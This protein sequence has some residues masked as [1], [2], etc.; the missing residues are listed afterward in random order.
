MNQLY[1][2][3][4]LDVLRRYVDDESVN[5][6]YL[7]PP[8][9]SERSYNVLFAEQ[10]GTRSAAQI[11]AF[12]DSWQWDQAAAAA[13]QEIVEEGGQASLTMQAFRHAIGENDLLAY[14]SMMAPRLVELRRV[15]RD[16]GSLYLHC[17]PTASHYLKMLL[18]A[19]F[20]PRNFR[21]EIV[22]KRS[23][24]HSDTKQGRKI[25]G[26]I[27]DVILFYSKSDDWTWNPVYTP[28]DQEYVDQFYRHVDES[29]R[30]YRLG[31]LTAAKPGG[32]TSY[33]F[34]GT[35]PY[36]GRYWAYSRRT[37]KSILRKGGYVF[38]RAAGR[39]HTSAISTKC[40]AFRC[41]TCGRTFDRLGASCRTS[42]LSDPETR[43]IVGA[44]C[45]HQHQY[46]RR[47]TRPVLRLW[48][49]DSGGAEA[50]SGVGRNRH[51]QSGHFVNQAQVDGWLRR[52]S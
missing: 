39:H 5:L 29:G 30:R 32:D 52:Q 3:D 10:D 35:R 22:W 33:E 46:R 23:S 41:R 24:A 50:R 18:D 47:C 19:V 49:Y 34:Q 20:G 42:R 31:D 15:L 40:P 21:T 17:D 7:D 25:H 27:H 1:Y 4:N 9:N 11:R 26:H 44:D 2:G 51:Y 14:L 12:E 48:N 43:S 37:W 6:V 16:S 28:Y 45:Q 36:K 13:F 8:F 38:P